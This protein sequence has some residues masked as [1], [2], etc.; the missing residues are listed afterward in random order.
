MANVLLEGASSGRVILA[1]NIPGCKETFDEDVTGFG[2]EPKDVNSL[3][4]AIE[5]FLALSY[6]EKKAMG[7]AGRDKIERE[8]NRQIVV[9]KYIE[10]VNLAE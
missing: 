6:E 4:V 7:K 5:K 2:F 9:D 10:Q 1:S 3:Q 8:F